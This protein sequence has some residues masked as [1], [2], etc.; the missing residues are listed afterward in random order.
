MPRLPE[1]LLD[2]CLPSVQAFDQQQLQQLLLQRLPALR[3]EV[4][5]G[6]DIKSP[7]RRKKAPRTASFEEKLQKPCF[8]NHVL[9][10]L[11]KFQ[12]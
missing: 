1:Q 10:Q 3:S 4:N 9:H 12:R 7:F 5:K 8:P 11:Q 2:V 6:R